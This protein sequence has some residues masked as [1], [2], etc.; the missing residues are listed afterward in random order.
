MQWPREIRGVNLTD[1]TMAKRNQ[2]RKSDRQ[3]SD[4]EKSEAVNQT[5]NTMA[6]RNQSVN[7]TDNAMAK[8]KRT[9]T[10]NYTKHFTE[11]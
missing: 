8:R 3:Y 1:N 7:L 5:D 2:S 10:N 11:N 6:K 9:W 4:Q